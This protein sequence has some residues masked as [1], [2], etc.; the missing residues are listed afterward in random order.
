MYCSP[1]IT[2]YDVQMFNIF[3]FIT[4]F[5]SNSRIVPL[6]KPMLTS[7]HNDFSLV[8]SLSLTNT[9]SESGFA[10]SY[11]LPY[12]FPNTVHKFI[13]SVTSHVSLEDSIQSHV[14]ISTGSTYNKPL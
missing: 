7:S 3:M 10:Y 2:P 11:I 5:L 12:S 1:T 13:F 6:Q 9:P 4:L 8:Q 14:I